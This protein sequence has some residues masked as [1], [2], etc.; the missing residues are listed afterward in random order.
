MNKTALPKITIFYPVVQAG[1]LFPHPIYSTCTFKKLNELG[2]SEG[3]YTAL[4]HLSE[5]AAWH[6]VC[7]LIG[8]EAHTETHTKSSHIRIEMKN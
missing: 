5:K 2:V 1:K 7:Y 3:Y 6:H 8:P 4:P